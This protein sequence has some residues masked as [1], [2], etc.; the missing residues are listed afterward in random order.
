MTNSQHDRFG[1][2]T[3]LLHVDRD[4]DPGTGVA[5]PIRQSVTYFAESG[6]AFAIRAIEPLNDQFY[7][8]HGNPTSSR[9]AR[10]ISDLEGA[11]ATLLTVSGMEAIATPCEHNDWR[12]GHTPKPVH[13]SLVM[14]RGGHCS[15]LCQH[16]KRFARPS[17]LKDQSLKFAFVVPSFAR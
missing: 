9:I 5:P 17:P 10:I 11:E 7:A 2:G 12:I 8:R 1:P 16:L 4:M 3:R 15:D 6:E 13:M 14:P